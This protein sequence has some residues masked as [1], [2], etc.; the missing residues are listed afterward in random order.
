[1]KLRA[2]LVVAC[3]CAGIGHAATDA[4]RA[5]AALEQG[6][7]AERGLNG[8]G[9]PKL[10]LIHYCE[11]GMLGSAEGYY[12]IG[13]LLHAASPPLRAPALANAYLALAA[14][15]GHRAAA[16]SN[17]V[18]HGFADL[19][20]DCMQFASLPDPPHAEGPLLAAFDIED[21]LQGMS[22]QRRQIADLIRARAPH[23]GVDTRFAL[24]VALAESNLNPLAVSP[25]NAQG[26]M[27]LIPETQERFG[28]KK[29]FDP[30]SNIRGALAYLR[31]LK[32]RFDG[33][34]ALVAAAYNAGEGVV[35]RFK[36]IPPY[37]ETRQYVRRVL[38]F[39]GR[40]ETK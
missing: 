26:V 20:D 12:R 19:F 5:V 16:E 38:Y 1:M 34:L 31:W 23:Y 3:L 27:Q 36:G 22:A 2:A 29:P 37:P 25:K 4:P 17:D 13:R 6:E 8:R 11:A 10:A 21:Y 7:L 32:A 35:E 28:V 15:L 14:R 30:E 39:A 18:W 33:D 40:A 24:A 9:H